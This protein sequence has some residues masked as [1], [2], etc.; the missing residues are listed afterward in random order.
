MSSPLLITS[1]KAAIIAQLQKDILPLQGLKKS[2]NLSS[3]N[4][5]PTVIKKAFTDAEFPLGAVH[6]F[7]CNG[8]EGFASTG[9]FVS[10]ILSSIMQNSGA[11][12]WISSSKTIFPPAL[13]WFGIE[14]EK[15]IFLELKREKEILW[16]MEEALKCDS[17]SAVVGEIKDLSFINSRRL[18]LAVEESRVTGFIL[19]SNTKNVNTTAC[20]TRWKITP[21][22]SE[23]IEDMPGVGFPRWNVELLKVR[24][25]KPGSWEIEFSGRR[26]KHISKV[27]AIE[28]EQKRKTG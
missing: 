10:G 18:Q 16:V 2:P 8:E 1:P 27:S 9:G 25:G 4:V 6:E 22:K 5:F 23:S 3:I 26:F 19:R 21:L 28:L 15:I 12:I 11:S 7:I 13:K 14:P 24:N 17:L 20:V